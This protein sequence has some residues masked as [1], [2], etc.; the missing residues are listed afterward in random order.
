[1]TCQYK[2]NQALDSGVA[3]HGAI[4]GNLLGPSA[5]RRAMGTVPSIERLLG[6]EHVA[7]RAPDD[8]SQEFFVTHT[9]EAVGHTD[10]YPPGGMVRLLNL[11]IAKQRVGIVAVN[12]RQ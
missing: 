7:S 3:R 2:L 1:M 10:Q 5:Q 11:H 12:C 9:L 8:D 4:L 6:V